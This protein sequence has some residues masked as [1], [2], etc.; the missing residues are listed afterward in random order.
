[1][2]LSAYPRVTRAC[3]KFFNPANRKP[4][5]QQGGRVGRE[6][7]GQAGRQAGGHVGT[8]KQRRREFS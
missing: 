2:S 6:G 8:K 5:N 1:M 7:T 3:E 4:A